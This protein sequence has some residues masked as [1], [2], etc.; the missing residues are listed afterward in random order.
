MPNGARRPGRWWLAAVASLLLLPMAAPTALAALRAQADPPPV[1]PARGSA[2]VVAQGLANLPA[3]EVAWSVAYRL[4]QPGA[5]PAREPLGPGFVAADQGSL[6]LDGDPPGRRAL[7][8]PGEAAFL[9]GIDDAERSVV[10]DRP[11][12]AFLIEIVP[13]ADAAA[14]APG[15]G[16]GTDPARIAVFASDPF[17]APAGERDLSLVRAVLTPG[18]R[19]TIA[20]GETPVLVVA[21]LGAITVRAGDNEPTPLRVGQA[22]SFRGDLELTGDGQAPSALLAGVIGGAVA[23][24]GAATPAPATPVGTPIATPRA[25]PDGPGAV[26]A[27]VYACPADVAP[28]EA[29]PTRCQRRSDV[30]SLLLT[31]LDGSDARQPAVA[32]GSDGVPV[33]SGLPL[34]DY[35]LR[36]TGLGDGFDRFFVAGLPGIGG[37][38]EAGYGASPEQGY[39]LRLSE[40]AP[41]FR[42]DVYALA[43]EG[44]GAA[45]PG[46]TAA[47]AEGET[48]SIA[49]RP[50]LCP[51]VE[52]ATFDPAAC[53][54]LTLPFEASLAGDALDAPLGLA[55]AEAAA[56]GTLVWDDLAL[57]EYV[58][59]QP[60]LPA[61]AATYYVPGSAAVGL[62]P[63][64]AGYG[65]VI[66]EGAAEIVLDV[67]NLAPA[68]APP[69]AAPPIVPPVA[70]PTAV[71]PGPTVIPVP[72]APTEPIGP[73]PVAPEP[74]AVP[75]AA[76]PAAGAD[77]DGD[78]LTDEVESATYG[79]DPA[80][81]DTDGDGVGDGDEVFAGTNP[82]AVDG[83][84]P[85]PT[86]AAE[87]VG[88]VDG[89]GD[90]LTDEV[91]AGIGTDP[92]NDDSDG[93][94]WLDSNEV[95]LGTDP[96]DGGSQPQS[97]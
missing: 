70:P 5:D 43:D 64:G 61:G 10:G 26:T 77:S 93:D 16:A 49:I 45:T 92:F 58:F 68:P 71:P 14:D 59:S 87:P 11:A 62:R 42:L 4:A 66:E 36:A 21:T 75:V 40:G 67:Y 38:P 96:L 65:V 28:A 73:E 90:G 35:A 30:V 79:T 83:G 6:L 1:S 25:G 50:L 63:D 33:W 94:G 41:A 80:V 51:G 60:V 39:R 29:T 88:T 55:E 86:P 13:A 54:P 19:T 46:A 95:D 56:D 23:G 72:I 53:A 18:E 37:P 12:G 91:E 84:A 57:G 27:V 20:A 22:A 3:G 2:Q 81:F 89:D 78:S 34:G 69:P 31:D 52:I 8:V 74:T 47:N 24:A 9:P 44:P 85:A 15:P 17:P 32:A 7:L 48:G 97:P 82:F 76:E